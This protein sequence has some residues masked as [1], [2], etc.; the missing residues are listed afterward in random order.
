VELKKIYYFLQIKY[1]I[2]KAMLHLMAVYLCVN[3]ADADGHG[4]GHGSGHGA[5]A[6]SANGHEEEDK[7]G[8]KQRELAFKELEQFGIQK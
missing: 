6:I 8:Q 2:A 1:P 4:S 5:N 7:C 3:V